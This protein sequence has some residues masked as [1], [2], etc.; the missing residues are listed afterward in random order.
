LAVV[1]S[2]WYLGFA[3][4]VVI[5]GIVVYFVGWILQFAGKI[6]NAANSVNANLAAIAASTEV[7]G[8]VPTVNS[9]LKDIAESC[10]TAR[11]VLE[12]NL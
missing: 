12:A 8:G 9:G 1:L 7:I 11:Q 10:I 2:G 5:I 6:A 3:V 4:A